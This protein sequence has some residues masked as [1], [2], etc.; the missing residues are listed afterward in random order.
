MRQLVAEFKTR[1]SH[2]YIFFNAPPLL[3]RSDTMAFSEMVDGIV[4][5]IEWGKTAMPDIQ[6]ALDLIPREKVLGF[7]MN[8]QE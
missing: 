4:I 8:R 6:K 2:R 3:R 5:V 1:Y 7:V